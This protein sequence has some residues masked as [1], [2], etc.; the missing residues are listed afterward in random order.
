MPRWWIFAPLFVFF[1]LIGVIALLY[2][3]DIAGLSETEVITHYAERYVV[4]SGNPSAHIND[5]YAV[6]GDGRVWLVVRCAGHEYA[7]NRF[8]GLI[9]YTSLTTLPPST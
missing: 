8:G 4:E 2:G 7:V 3:K 5:C 6:P 9:T 1:G